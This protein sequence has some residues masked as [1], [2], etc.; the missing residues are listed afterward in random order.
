MLFTFEG[1]TEAQV[2]LRLQKAETYINKALGVEPQK[3]VQNFDLIAVQ[4]E[5]LTDAQK[6]EKK[7]QIFLKAMA[8]SREVNQFLDQ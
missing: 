8:E 2:R 5:L 7:K 1:E 6:K 4:D 3:K